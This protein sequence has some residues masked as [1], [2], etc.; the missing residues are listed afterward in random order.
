MIYFRSRQLC[1]TIDIVSRSKVDAFVFYRSADKRGRG[2]VNGVWPALPIIYR[3]TYEDLRRKS[4][5]ETCEFVAAPENAMGFVIGKKGNTIKQIQEKSGAKITTQTN[6]D[7]SSG[8]TVYGTEEQ[9]A[10]ARE[11]INQKVVSR[12]VTVTCCGK[13]VEIR[14]NAIPRSQF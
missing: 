4:R 7:S 3:T 1:F 11:L 10:R 5:G 12:T 6:N 9:R 13:W 14:V 2:E 8:F